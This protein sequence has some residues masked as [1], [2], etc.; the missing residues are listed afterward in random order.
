VSVELQSRAD[1]IHAGIR[2]GLLYLLEEPDDLRDRVWQQFKQSEAQLAFK[3]HAA[4]ERRSEEPYYEFA[5]HQTP[6]S[7][8][9]L[10]GN[11]SEQSSR[12]RGAR[13]GIAPPHENRSELDLGPCQSADAAALPCE[14]G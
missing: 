14:A 10:G 7:T 1:L 6:S 2:D 12:T 4:A 13:S 11:V 8:G 3:S 5:E 9:G